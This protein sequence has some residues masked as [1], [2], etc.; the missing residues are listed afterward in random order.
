MGGGGGVLC[1]PEFKGSNCLIKYVCWFCFGI[2]VDHKI[3][4]FACF[5][6]R[7][8]THTRKETEQEEQKDKKRGSKKD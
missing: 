3:M 5:I 1:A 8:D 7:K 2:F 6:F 4:C